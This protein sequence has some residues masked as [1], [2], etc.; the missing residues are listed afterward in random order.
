MFDQI[1]DFVRPINRPSDLYS[2]LLNEEERGTQITRFNQRPRFPLIVSRLRLISLRAA[3][4]TKRLFIGNRV[5]ML[6][7]SIGIIFDLVPDR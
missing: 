5:A 3:V 7:V 1:P 2:L 4:S 6:V